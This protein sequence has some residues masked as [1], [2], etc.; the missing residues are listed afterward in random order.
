MQWTVKLW[1]ISWDDGKGQY[2]VSELPDNMQVEIADGVCEDTA[3]AVEYAMSEASANTG[4][5]IEGVTTTEVR[6]V[7]GSRRR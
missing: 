7:A 3:E 6:A 5:L 2:D 1:G 4:S